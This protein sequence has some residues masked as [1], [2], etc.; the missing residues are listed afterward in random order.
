MIAEERLARAFLDS[1]PPRAAMTLEQMPV[2]Q[3]VA[4]LRAVP[5]PS[6]AAV[7]REMTP[8][9]AA[10]CAGRL[11]S[12]EAA[13]IVSV[14]VTDDAAAVVRAMEAEPRE[15]LLAALP[16]DTRADLARVLQ[17]PPGTAGAV[18]DPS[19][20]QLPDDV[21]VANARARLRRA[22]RGLLYYLYVVD[23]EHRLVG[24]LDIPEL[25]LARPRDP[26]S[27]VMH[28]D[29]TRLSAWLPVALV[30]EH[31]GWHRYHALPVVDEADRLLGAIRYQ[32]LR[33]LER[34]AAGRGPDPALLT[35]RALA[36]LF[37]LGTRGLIAGVAGA[38]PA[39]RDL[40]SQAGRANAAEGEVPDAR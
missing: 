12:E 11:A 38:A 25:L 17:Y 39:G 36:E 2:T 21:A 27:S 37:Q 30:R 18:M 1:Q 9:H 22:G 8:P 13:G 5:A 3:A 40:E 19:I 32:T 4:V 28:R 35:A 14:M 29:V 10:D 26:V 15:R 31:A 34:E 24:V 33:R 6:A 7:L 23:R 20:V 16:A